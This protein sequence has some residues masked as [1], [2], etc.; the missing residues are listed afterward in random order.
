MTL[1]LFC[2]IDSFISPDSVT[3]CSLIKLTNCMHC[4]ALGR[5]GRCSGLNELQM[6]LLSSKGLNR[7][8]PQTHCQ[9]LA[10]SDFRPKSGVRNEGLQS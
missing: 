7:E 10:L 6:A 9:K 4:D 1:F 8:L 5:S 3:F 2:Q